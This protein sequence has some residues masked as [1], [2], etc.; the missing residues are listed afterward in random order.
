M[1]LIDFLARWT[2]PAAL[3]MA[4][5]VSPVTAQSEVAS[6][7][8][9]PTAIHDT[10]LTNLLS[11]DHKGL[12]NLSPNRLRKLAGLTRQTRKGSTGKVEYTRK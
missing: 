8:S 4:L 12:R 5:A 2:A 1:K 7:S 3:V 11:Q 9:D 10:A 6:T